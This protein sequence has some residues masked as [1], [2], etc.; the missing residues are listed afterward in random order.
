M[1]LG[2]LGPLAGLVVIYFIKYSSSKF[3]DFLDVFIHDNRLITSVGTLS[4]L[5]NALLF[6]LYVQ[7]D[8]YQTFKGIFIVTLIY[9]I[10]ILVLKILN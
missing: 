4:L 9:G 6:A 3:G 8:K 5:A 7:L 10:L 2:L 1:I